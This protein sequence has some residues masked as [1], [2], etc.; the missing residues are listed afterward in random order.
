MQPQS[1]EEVVEAIVAKDKR[2][3]LEAY[4]F[5]REALDFTQ[6]AISKANKGKLRHI[7]GQ[8]LLAGVR[9][10]GLQQYGPMT[11]TL[12]EEW[13][14]RRCEDFGEIVFSLV[15]S[16]LFS[17]TE[18]DTRADFAGV[19]DFHEVFRKPFTPS[20][21]AEATLMKSPART[22]EGP[23]PSAALPGSEA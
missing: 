13:G 10:Y 1:F 14:L 16:G 8:E 6:K 19:F 12:F 11:L 22:D 9:A 17:K 21:A 7:T 20:R 2:Y 5:V 3:D 23:S 15:E 4:N 18:E